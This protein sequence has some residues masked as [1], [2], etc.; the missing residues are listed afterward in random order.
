MGRLR[1]SLNKGGENHF[2][3]GDH[4]RPFPREKVPE[5]LSEDG[6]RYKQETDYDK[7]ENIYNS[8]MFANVVLM[9]FERALECGGWRAEE[10]TEWFNKHIIEF[11]VELVQKIEGR[12]YHM[13][14][15]T[16]GNI[17]GEKEYFH[18]EHFLEHLRK[19]LYGK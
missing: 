19:Y 8:P 5:S 12:L 13:M 15:H 16:S 17:I 1:P 6:W 3:P 11:K 4:K 2:S 7:F 14:K 18:W 9:S 10:F